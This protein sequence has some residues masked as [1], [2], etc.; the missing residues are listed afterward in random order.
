MSMALPPVPGGSGR[1]DVRHRFDAAVESRERNHIKAMVGVI[2]DV[3]LKAPDEIPHSQGKAV[4]VKDLR[5]ANK[6]WCAIRPM[7]N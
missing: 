3:V 1:A 5:Q 7:N 6:P 4:R 2:C